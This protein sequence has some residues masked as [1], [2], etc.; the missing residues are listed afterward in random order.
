MS[1]TTLVD[2]DFNWTFLL[3][4]LFGFFV[5]LLVSMFGGGGGFYYVPILTLLFKIPTQLAVA[6]S[7]AA[8]IPTTVFGSIGHYRQGNLNLSVGVILGIGG[9]FGAL[10]GSYASSLVSSELLGRFF[11]VFMI[12]LAIPMSISRKRRVDMTKKGQALLPQITPIKSVFGSMFG[13]LSGFM[14]GLFG[15][16]GSPPVVA[17]LYIL[18]LPAAAVIGT[19]LFVLLFN[20]VS[21]LFGHIVMGQFNLMLIALLGSGSAIGALVGPRFL[22]KIKTSALESFFGPVFI[23]MILVLGIV[24]VL[25]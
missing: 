7:L 16:S 13:L 5:G 2:L 19:S 4:P 10:I 23:S 1:V 25:R 22:G 24:M 11:G 15:L 18:E 20:A 14:S 3:L 21:G 17:G 9:I 8:I 6:T 12:V